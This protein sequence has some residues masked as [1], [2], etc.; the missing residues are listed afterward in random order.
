MPAI[1]T[2]TTCGSLRKHGVRT[3][4]TICSI[5]AD[6]YLVTSEYFRV[7]WSSAYQRDDRPA[8]SKGVCGRVATE[9]DAVALYER[10]CE[11]AEAWYEAN[12]QH[13]KVEGRTIQIDRSGV[14]QGWRN[15]T[16]SDLP[17]NI[18]AEIECEI[19]DGGKE[20]TG[21][22]VATNGCVYRW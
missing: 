19:I 13:D 2:K 14:G 16:A 4:T 15:A 11:A 6:G 5:G 7:D 10:S 22:Y 21:R 18:L 17:A 9:E 12:R 20:S 3:E 1:A 8:V